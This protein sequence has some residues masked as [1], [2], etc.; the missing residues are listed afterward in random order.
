MP[1]VD[2]PQIAR[3]RQLGL[4]DRFGLVL[5]LGATLDNLGLHARL[6]AGLRIVVQGDPDAHQALSAALPQWQQLPDGETQVWPDVVAATGGTIGWYQYSVRGL[7]GPV[8]ADRLSSVYP[9]LACLNV[10]QRAAVGVQDLV[11]RA[12]SLQGDGSAGSPRMLILDLPG[13]EASLIQALGPA[14]LQAFDWILCRA[15]RQPFGD[16]VPDVQRTRE[17][18]GG[19]HYTRVWSSGDEPNGL[20]VT[21]LNRFDRIALDLSTWRDRSLAAE[22]ECQELRRTHATAAERAVELTLERETLR[23]RLDEQLAHARQL[24]EALAAGR[25]AL[26]Q[27]LAA[28]EAVRKERDDEA[29]RSAGLSSRVAELETERAELDERLRSA[30]ALLEANRQRADEAEQAVAREHA[31]VHEQS[32]RAD[33]HARIGTERQA[34]LE[35]LQAELAQL[36][37]SLQLAQS[38]SQTLEK[39]LTESR[40]QAQSLQRQLQNSESTAAGLRAELQAEGARL[41]ALREELARADAQLDLIKDLLLHA[42]LP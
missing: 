16:G 27:A 23:S 11:S 29:A 7:N 39:Q 25:D 17:L 1:I 35:R 41:V 30:G 15:C 28:A 37:K 5:H 6:P 2:D 31:R 12:L 19:A 21:E 3:I 32:Q 42:S 13:Q 20:L 4:P 33:R 14:G 22:A 9:R 8:N 34:E 10:T 40:S 18:L 26:S 38:G 36:Q 24:D